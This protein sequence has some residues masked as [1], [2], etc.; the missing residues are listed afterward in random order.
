[1]LRAELKALQLKKLQNIVN[2]AYE[3]V[4][5]YK[6]KFDELKL[7]PSHIKTLADVK[8]IPYTVKDD[9]RTNYPYG[10]FAV[11]TDDIVRI[12]A[13]SGTTGKPIVAG[14]TKNDLKMWTEC[15][16][17]LIAAVG[18]SSKD[19]V[20]IAFG[21]GLFTGALGLHQGFEKLGATV[22]PASSGNTERQIMLLKDLGVTA[23]V[24]T[25]SYALHIAETAQKMGVTKNDLK[26]RIG[27]FGSEAST[28][29]MHRE[30][31][32]RLGMFT[33]DN[34][35]LTEI[36]GPG[37]SGDCVHKCG[38]HI[39]EDHFLAEIMDIER[40]VEMAEGDYGEMVLT[41]LSKEGMPILRYRT[42][43]ITAVDNSPC[44]CGR[45]F[46]RMLRIKGRS[47]DMLKIRGVNV[48]PSQIESVLIDCADIGNHY[49]I[50]VLREGYLDY[51]E[52]YVEVLNPE[53]L[54]DF[55]KLDAL[56]DRIRNSIKTVLSI[57][58]KVR[59]VEPQSLKRYE[60]KAKRVFDERNL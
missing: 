1:M 41:T 21:Y 60:G 32:D 7:K 51:L 39:N 58:V 31:A 28:P 22:V 56:R 35:G 13:S 8:L 53:L 16:A 30:I 48:F 26:L 10:L 24:S 5:F 47:D 52:I 55:G 27:L 33:S 44:A 6:A 20:Q 17:R 11:P 46:G 43:D 29:E 36:M 40:N 54:T 3:R 37:V 25:P 42:K 57:D 4:P 59:L 34:Y 2:I 14:Y 38:M 12:H 19:I 50:H 18:G 45:T 9:L 23:L 15:M 49:E